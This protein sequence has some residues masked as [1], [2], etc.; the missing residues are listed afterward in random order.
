MYETQL[1]YIGL[2]GAIASILSRLMTG[3][4]RRVASTALTCFFLLSM[5]YYSLLERTLAGLIG[6]TSSIIGI[7]AVLSA[8]WL[9]EEEVSTHNLLI[10]A[11]CISSSLLA[12]SQDLVKIF[13]EWEI[14][15]SAVVSLTAYHRDRESAEAALKYIM[16]CGAGTALA[17]GGIVLVFVEKGATTLEATYSSSLLAKVLL[18]A[19]FGV[20]AA[21]FPLHFWLPDAHMAAP[22]T[23]S[24]VLSGIAIESAAVLVYRLVVGDTIIRWIIMPLALTGA[25][26]ANLSAYRQEDLKRLLAFSS[27]A[28]ANYILLAW[29]SANKLASSY[30]FLHIVAHGFLKSALFIISGVLLATYGTRQLSKLSGAASKNNALKITVVLSCIGLTGAPPLL[31]FWSE[32]YMGVGLFQFNSLIGLGFMIAVIISFVYYFRILYILASG[33]REEEPG[34]KGPVLVAL[35]LTILSLLA[36]ALCSYLISYFNI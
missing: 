10:L 15:G 8:Y 6:L 35:A 27:V 11:L 31:A 26:V 29:S 4:T 18:L 28:N 21:L 32:L 25:I 2:F 20:E 33:K 12:S 9:L 22:S 30:A 34:F 24:A 3:K 7:A 14:L 19:G 17:L 16:L 5:L 1:I 13:I 36:F 23:A